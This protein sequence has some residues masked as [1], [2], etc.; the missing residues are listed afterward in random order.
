M[1]APR[2]LFVVTLLGVFLALAFCIVLAVM[3]R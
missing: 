1:K 2:T 3:H